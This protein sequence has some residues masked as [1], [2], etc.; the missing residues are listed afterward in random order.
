M[1][2]VIADE[3]L[4]D[5][6]KS[7]IEPLEICDEAEEVFGLFRPFPDPNNLREVSD[8]AKTAFTEQELEEARRSTVWDTT[9]QGSGRESRPDLTRSHALRGNE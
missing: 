6:L 1:T 4:K 3:P 7:S 8:W 5:R 2:R 9:D